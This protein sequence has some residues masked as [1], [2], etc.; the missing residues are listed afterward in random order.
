MIN[1]VRTPNLTNIEHPNKI[2]KFI[3]KNMKFYFVPNLYLSV[4]S[5]F[6]NNLRTLHLEMCYNIQYQIPLF[7]QLNFQNLFELR[8]T[9]CGLTDFCGIFPNLQL[10]DLRFNAFENDLF[11]SK[12]TA[13]NL[14]TV[15][16]EGNDVELSDKII[17]IKGIPILFMASEQSIY[18]VIPGQKQNKQF[19]T[20]NFTEMARSSVQYIDLVFV[21][22]ILI[23]EALAQKQPRYSKNIPKIILYCLILCYKIYKLFSNITNLNYYR[24]ENKTANLFTELIIITV[25]I[26]QIK[27]EFYSLK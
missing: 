6:S 25:V 27:I 5:S 14:E 11:L 9:F 17:E 12:I 21:I 1:G 20:I 7:N 2:R 4:L 26:V 8:I 22:L 23:V 24:N 19:K 13:Q 16:L 15:M 18:Q 3:G 10:L